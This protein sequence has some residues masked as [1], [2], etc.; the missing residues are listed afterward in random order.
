MLEQGLEEGLRFPA[1]RH[2]QVQFSAEQADAMSLS[3]QPCWQATF[4]ATA[5]VHSVYA[6]RHRTAVI[7]PHRIGPMMPWSR[8]MMPRPGTSADLGGV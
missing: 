8:G 3:W 2:A 5:C 4:N 1:S 6:G 7:E